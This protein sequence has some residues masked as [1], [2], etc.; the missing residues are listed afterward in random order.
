MKIMQKPIPAN[1]KWLVPNYFH[2][3][4]KDM[5]IDSR[6]MKNCHAII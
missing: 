4:L 6:N 1:N 3:S 2:K 5:D